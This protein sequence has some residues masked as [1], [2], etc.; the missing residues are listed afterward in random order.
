MKFNEAFEGFLDYRRMMGMDE[1]TIMSDRQIVY[2]TFAHSIS[3]RDI[4]TF[5][6]ADI[7]DIMVAGQVHGVFSSTIGL[8][9]E[10]VFPILGG[11]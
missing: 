11:F 4:A 9:L 6:M 7:G 1:T 8:D 10:K 2:G 3:N 5:T